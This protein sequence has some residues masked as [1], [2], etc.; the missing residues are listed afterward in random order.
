MMRMPAAADKRCKNRRRRSFMACPLG[1]VR[2][3]FRRG[4][5]A[6]AGSDPFQTLSSFRFDVSGANHLPPLLCFFGDE[7]AKIRGRA[8]KY[9]SPHGSG[10]PLGQSRVSETIINFFVE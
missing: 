4:D 10:E 6:M 8:R 7:L 3:S 5:N 1:R 2:I 9:C